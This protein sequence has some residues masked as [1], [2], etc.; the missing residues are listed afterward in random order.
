M[1]MPFKVKIKGDMVQL[2]VIIQKIFLKSFKKCQ[3]TA[4]LGPQVQNWWGV[5]TDIGQ[6]IRGEFQWKTQISDNNEGWA[7]DY[8]HH[9]PLVIWPQIKNL[10]AY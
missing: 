4:I 1:A 7:G 3:V 10:E 2:G 5:Q 8:V 9:N 6:T